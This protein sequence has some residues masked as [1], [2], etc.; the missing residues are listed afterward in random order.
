WFQFTEK[1]NSDWEHFGG[2]RYMPK[3]NFF[4]K[5]AEDWVVSIALYWQAF[6]VDGFRCDAAKEPPHQFWKRLRK[7]LK[8]RD[9]NFLL[10]GEIWDNAN[11]MIPYFR[12]E[13][14]MVFDY[15]LFYPLA[16]M[17]ND[18]DRLGFIKEI[19]NIRQSF[20][21]NAQ[22]VRF[23]ANH[24][25]T[26]ALSLFGGDTLRLM[27]ALTI[28][29]TLPGT[30]MIYYGD[31]IGMTGTR[32]P[33]ENIR[34]RVEWKSINDKNEILV[35][36]R[37]LARMRRQSPVLQT[38]HSKEIPS[39]TFLETASPNVL[40]YLRTNSKDAALLVVANISDKTDS[41]YS[42]KMSS[43][44]TGKYKSRSVL[45]TKNKTFASFN[46]DSSYKPAPVLMP[47]QTFVL[48]LVSQKK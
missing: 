40:A 20:P 15:A 13:F 12:D 3:I 1:D 10:L 22:L 30:P 6:G 24:D 37:N 17:I 23:L 7:E 14:D 2:S 46:A 45:S 8:S 31:E 19:E 16:K 43:L 28:L 33:D 4:N 18:G 38:E 29:W 21:K 25:N 32:P 42:V 35:Q 48:E 36:H 47:R 11:Y 41:S 34:K 9:K 44:K 5:E 39:I 26:R 27:Q